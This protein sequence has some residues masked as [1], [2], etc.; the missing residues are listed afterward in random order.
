MRCCYAYREQEFSCKSR[1]TGYVQLGWCL[2]Q[3]K[4]S[5]RQKSETLQGDCSN[6][7]T[8]ALNSNGSSSRTDLPLSPGSGDGGERLLIGRG[9][10]KL[11][12][13]NYIQR[14]DTHLKRT[15]VDG[16]L[17]MTACHRRIGR[18]RAA[19][20]NSWYPDNLDNDSR[21]WWVSMWE[22]WMTGWDEKSMSG[23]RQEDKKFCSGSTRQLTWHA[24]WNF[25]K[26]VGLISRL[27]LGRSP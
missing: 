7:V 16:G 24:R 4:I 14:K 17:T 11:A 19:D 9:C 26:S 21:R 15:S 6:W 13:T 5:L 18:M 3:Q 22:T 10:I 25:P 2:L 1:N 20:G 23:L 12:W 8:S 27:H